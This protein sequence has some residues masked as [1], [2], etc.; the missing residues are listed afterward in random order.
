MR[1]MGIHVDI[2]LA[3]GVPF[4]CSRIAPP[5]MTRS[6]TA[7]TTR[8][9]LRIAMA[10]FVSGPMGKMLISLGS[11]RTRSIKI[12]HGMLG[13]HPGFRGPAISS[14]QSRCAVHIGRA[15][16]WLNEGHRLLRHRDMLCA[17]EFQDG[18]RIA[19]GFSSVT[20]PWVV[21]RASSLTSGEASA[22]K[23]ASASSTPG[24]VSI[25]ICVGG[26]RIGKVVEALLLATT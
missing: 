15:A 18:K 12:V 22:N 19:G 26:I 11:A 17:T 13:H 25:M 24:S 7:S 4:P 20:L 9:S 16:Q 2:E 3:C 6:F 8:G 21:V 23:N 10:M 1:R 14:C 5:I